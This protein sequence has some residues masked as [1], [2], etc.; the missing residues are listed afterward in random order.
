MSSIRF[1]VCL[2]LYA[3]IS[4]PNLHA[5]V[6]MEKGITTLNK[7]TGIFPIDYWA[8]L[9]LLFKS[10]NEQLVGAPF[11]HGLRGERMI[12]KNLGLKIDVNCAY[13]GKKFSTEEEKSTWNYATNQLEHVIVVDHH[14]KTSL[15]FRAML[16]FNFYSYPTQ[17][18]INYISFS[19]GYNHVFR[20]ESVNGEPKI[21]GL[22]NSWGFDNFPLSSRFALGTKWLVTEK[23]WLSWEFGIFG[24]SP[25]Q[26]GLEYKF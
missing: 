22:I 26:I 16:G 21:P 14:R 11:S 25:I 18:S 7:Y 17:N 3:L 4:P 24:G 15:K 1:V 13:L 2:F 23:M 20:K 10:K 5:Q 19:F 8:E 6:S 9:G 12:R